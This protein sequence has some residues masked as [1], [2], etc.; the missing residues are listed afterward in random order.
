MCQTETVLAGAA[1]TAGPV[2]RAAHGRSFS[3]VRVRVEYTRGQGM[4]M[5]IVRGR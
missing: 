3:G 1:H 2:V 5:I 4:P